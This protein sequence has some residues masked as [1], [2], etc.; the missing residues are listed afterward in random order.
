M[1]RKALALAG[2]LGVT[3]VVA[4]LG[5]V[6]TATSVGT[7]YQALAKPS[8]NPPAWLFGPVWT[9]LYLAMA[10]AAWL[11]WLHRGEGRR[12]ALLLFAVQLALNATWSWLFF[13]GRAPAAALV[14]IVL[15]WLAVAATVASFARLRPAAAWLLVPYLAWVTFAGALNAAIVHLN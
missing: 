6:A 9:A 10:V 3:A 4:L 8:W 5:S 14:D 1:A 11:V 12:Q 15:L 13:F 7:W 2:F